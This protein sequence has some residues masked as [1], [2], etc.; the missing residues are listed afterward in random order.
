MMKNKMRPIL[1][2]LF[3]IQNFSKNLENLE[4]KIE[5]AELTTNKL[6]PWALENLKFIC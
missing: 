3:W 1:N 4:C 2:G 6:T 5:Q